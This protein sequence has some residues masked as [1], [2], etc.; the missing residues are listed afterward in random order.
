MNLYLP[1][2]LY[3]LKR[4]PQR[5][6]QVLHS[7]TREQSFAKLFPSVSAF[8]KQTWVLALENRIHPDISIRGT[9]LFLSENMRGMLSLG[10]VTQPF[11]QCSRGKRNAPS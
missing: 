8:T 10:L 2:P 6:N 5:K 1:T 7:E 3:K 4:F 9:A 11:S